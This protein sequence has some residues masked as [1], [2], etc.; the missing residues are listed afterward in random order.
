MSATQHK[1]RKLVEI[2]Q[3]ARG[4]TPLKYELE[5]I[6]FF[7][8]ELPS[9]LE[10]VSFAWERGSKL[11]TTDAQPVNPHT[12]A[13][14]WKQ[15]LRQTATLYKEGGRL[16]P[17]EFTFKVQ[18]VRGSGDGA[19]SSRKTIGKLKLDMSTFCSEE[20][21]PVPQ[22]VFL[23]LKPAGKLK[24][25]IK[26][27]WLRDAKVDMEALTEASFTTHKSGDAALAGLAEDEQD[28][29]GFEAVHLD[30]QEPQQHHMQQQYH[31]SRGMSQDR[32]SS[33]SPKTAT[34]RGSGS[35]GSSN[36]MQKQGLGLG[37][38]SS[39]ASTSPRIAAA[40]VYRKQGPQVPGAI[41]AFSV[42]LSPDEERA[43]AEQEKARLAAMK[44]VEV[45]RMRR[46]IEEQLRSELNDALAKHNKTTW[47]D[48][49]C[50]CFPRK[51]GVRITSQEMGA[52]DDNENASLAQGAYL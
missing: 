5:V 24:V 46:N 10:K 13:V 14:F 50:C 30:P 11:F 2:S 33:G 41:G 44:E 9:G 31:H 51:Q 19:N 47:R 34:G 27:S 23:Q 3:K 15:Y 16:L 25:S 35:G 21:A 32:G 39:Q 28:L 4:R 48:M 42:G 1:T 49:F 17:K 38:S 52:M 40:G 43:A 22:E 12:R 6:P 26:A 36:S 8:G 18:H 45:E 37:D 29:S 7:A 20:T